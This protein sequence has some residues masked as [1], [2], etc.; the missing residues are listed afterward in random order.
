M[1]ICRSRLPTLLLVLVVAAA[2]PAVGEASA[3][4]P[5][6]VAK[7]LPPKTVQSVAP[8]Q[9]PSG[10]GV[11]LK[12]ELTGWSGVEI[13]PQELISGP[14]PERY[15]RI[16]QGP[17]FGYV[18]RDLAPSSSGRYD[19]EVYFAVRASLCPGAATQQVFFATDPEAP[20]GSPLMTVDVCAS[21]TLLGL[22]RAAKLTVLGASL[23]S[24]A[25][26]FRFVAVQGNAVVS[27]I[28]IAPE[29]ELQSSSQLI[30][31][32]QS[33][34][35]YKHD[36]SG[37]YLPPR[38]LNFTKLDVREAVV[39]RFGSRHTAVLAPQRLGFYYSALG[40]D[41]ADL[42]DLVV[43]A[44]VDNEVRALPL[45]DRYPLFDSVRQYDSPTGVR[46][47]ANDPAVG[48]EMSLDIKAPFWPQD[49]QT[50][51]LPSLFF[52]LTLTNTSPSAITPNITVALPV[53]YDG[54]DSAYCPSCGPKEI[55]PLAGV[56]GIGWSSIE[57]VG[58]S[59]KPDPGSFGGGVS[60]R[61]DYAL[62][63]S[64][65][66]ITDVAVAGAAGAD[67]A[68][69]SSWLPPSTGS[70]VPETG[71]RVFKRVPRG[72]TGLVFKA[73]A[74]PPDGTADAEAALTSF[75]SGD[76]VA[77]AHPGGGSA[78]YVF[79]YRDYFADMTSVVTASVALRDAQVGRSV[80]FDSLVAGSSGPDLGPAL[81]S[82]TDALRRLLAL[83]YRSY[84]ANAWWLSRSSGSSALP[85]E[86]FTVSE[87]SGVCCRFQSTV[88]VTYNDS[89]LLLAMWPSLL[90]KMLDLWSLYSGSSPPMPGKVVPHD[91]G[92]AQTLSGQAYIPMPVEENTNYTLLAY[93]HWKATGD[94]ASAA[95]RLP[96]L[97]ELMSY[98]EA[99][100]SDADGLPDVGVANTIDAANPTLFKSPGQIYLGLKSA[101]A[102]RAALEMS[103]AFGDPDQAFRDRMDALHH[104]VLHSIE[105]A[106][107]RGDHFAVSL[108]PSSDSASLRAFGS[109]YPAGTLIFNLLYG[110]DLPVS[111]S[112]LDRM[113]LDVRAVA[114]RTTGP[115]GS[116][117][118]ER[119][120]V[121]G[122]ASQSILRD[123]AASMLGANRDDAFTSYLSGYL[124]WQD[125]LSRSG[126]G[127]WWDTFTYTGSAQSGFSPLTGSTSR[128]VL[129]YHPRG[130]VLYGY[131]QSFAGLSLD[132][133][134]AIL[135]TLPWA[136][137][138]A[139]V[140]L[141][142]LADWST[143]RVPVAVVQAT[144]PP[145]VIVE[146]PTTASSGLSVV[147][148]QMTS[149]QL[150]TGSDSFAPSLGETVQL[151]VQG[152]TS[153]ASLSAGHA[154]N[155]F[156]QAASATPYSYLWDGLVG[157]APATDAKGTVC[158]IA[159]Q[160]SP[161]A[162]QAP[163]CKELG[164]DT[165]SPK[166]A[167]DWYVAEGAT[168]YGF[169]T[170][171]LIQNPGG[172][173][174]TVEVTYL[175]P[176]GPV[177]KAPLLVPAQSRR[178]I[179]VAADLPGAEVSTRIRSDQPV[180][181]ERAMYWRGSDGSWREGHAV[182]GT[183]SP[184]TT[185]YLAEG[186]TNWGFDEWILL[187]NPGAAD[188]AA[189]LRFVAQDGR[190]LDHDVVVKAG[191]RMTIKVADLM[192][193]A[194]VATE[195]QS[196]Q[197]IVAERAMYW[198]GPYPA[199]AGGSATIGLRAPSQTWFLA[200]GSS[201]WGFETWLLLLN[202][203]D[204]EVGVDVVYMTQSGPVVRPGITMPPRSRQSIS[205]GWDIGPADSSIFIRASRPVLAERAMYYSPDGA[206]A[207][208]SR[209]GHASQ[210]ASSPSR[211]WRLAEG[212]TGHG[213][214]EY[215]LV[216]NPGSTE[217]AVE[218]VLQTEG[219]N[220]GSHWYSVAPGARLTVFLNSVISDSDVSVAVNSSAPVVV[221]RAMY[222][223][224]GV[225]YLVMH[226]AIG[227]K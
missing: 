97:K 101:A 149:P 53:S 23:P 128:G 143:G 89:H 160:P 223:R 15:A 182:V 29:G 166:P 226:G 120:E 95:A 158:A 94:N 225:G 141:Y 64:G 142:S 68:A 181:V 33:R 104:R 155:W 152:G 169:E 121:S 139:R 195:I 52:D 81:G 132:R 21:G 78:G 114:S 117:H 18:V 129:G 135:A 168:A 175:T 99:A 131:A 185:W 170:Y 218:I 31:S 194:D 91:V 134:S 79:R 161:G 196:S 22:V 61:V 39:S 148:R 32:D 98:V 136:R 82:Q 203:N 113:I 1:C 43:L 147:A 107:W 92:L 162:L 205:M 83:A 145:S 19:I 178:T 7:P 198:G 133:S 116:V 13:L 123:M 27:Q 140:P 193:F 58:E 102:A 192:P 179:I 171:L 41:A 85:A 187:Q 71:L 73:G 8:S 11:P 87:G 146:N 110:G 157:S 118:M 209:A 184:A 111:Q 164:V 191:T 14:N 50:S 220:A 188:A 183:R 215:V 153:R 2:T 77:A 109:I 35:N 70:G 66:S 40:I 156:Y 151:S 56:K 144:S 28:R 212:S 3:A 46:M 201:N 55:T 119:G 84:A 106:A 6:S 17:S 75:V 214:Y 163:S 36:P 51:L 72:Y 208:S 202:P 57:A 222:T 12:I 30:P 125:L 108:D 217:A 213:L 224:D 219:G 20:L 176:H 200:E 37:D 24:R 26:V 25:A 74:L 90:A 49:E 138:G 47:V 154:G 112:V 210:G 62:V 130:A 96:F 44:T 54:R 186:S 127:G 69:S 172:A 76:V 4:Y 189:R 93:A 211:T 88:D 197:P 100:D 59:S 180:V 165:N 173:A 103:S 216:Q 167:T 48:I 9:V 206:P 150:E 45:T 105:N 34:L 80:D 124:A 177:P 63:A 204:S 207:G 126:D 42:Q 159:P 67:A 122:W 199:A 86:I 60:V 137:P 174:A 16:R 221:E 227:A 115:Y 38:D 190:R 10:G 5:S 65:G